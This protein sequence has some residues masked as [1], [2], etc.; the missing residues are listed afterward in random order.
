MSDPSPGPGQTDFYGNTIRPAPAR[1]PNDGGPARFI[2][3][4]RFG[5]RGFRTFGSS[6]WS[7][8]VLGNINPPV[9]LTREDVMMLIQRQM[10]RPGIDLIQIEAV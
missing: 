1:N 8:D 10:K 7:S 4:I 6:G 2:V 3:R 5:R 9:T